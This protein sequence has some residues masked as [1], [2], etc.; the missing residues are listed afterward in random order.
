MTDM[1]SHGTPEP[2]AERRHIL[3]VHEVEAELARA[4]V[5]RSHRTVLR[6]CQ[7]GAFDAIKIAGPSGDEWYV[8]PASVPKVIG[9]LRQ[10]DVQ[11]ARRSGPRPAMT[12]DPLD[13]AG[14]TTD[15]A[16]VSHGGPDR[17]EAHDDTTAHAQPQPAIARHDSPAQD[18]F[19][20]PYVKQLEER[21]ERF[22]KK[23]DAL[24]LRNE[25]REARRQKDMLELQ[26]MITVGQSETLAN[27]MLKAKELI[28]P[29]TVAEPPEP[30]SPEAS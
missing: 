18:I 5:H 8:A 27:F 2:A 14:P 13:E 19:A 21:A 25:E 7:S 23:Y 6:L 20:H 10:I 30:P 9:D 24:V 1:A 22:E 15:T 11:R 12:P 3:T 29:G 4:N 17:A 16:G 28:A 26:R